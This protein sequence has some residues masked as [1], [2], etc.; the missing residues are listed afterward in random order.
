M[1]RTCI[2]VSGSWMIDQGSL[3]PGYKRA[4]ANDDYIR[5]LAEAG[6]VPLILPF[7]REK[8]RA[9]VLER[10]V[11]LVDGLILSGGHDLY[12]PFYG[13][14]PKQKLSEVWPERDIFDRQLFELMLEAKKPVLGICRGFQL[15]NALNGGELLQDLSYS[16]KPLLKHWQNQSPEMPIHKVFFEPGNVFHE[17]FGP[18]LMVNSHHHQV[19]IAEGS[20]LEVCGRASDGVIEAIADPERKI[21]A[22]QWHPEMMTVNSEPMRQLF[23]HFVESCGE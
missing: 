14:E 12:P 5:S 10:W 22:V 3:F 6:A 2:G 15:I 1:K 7:V 19:V 4:Y 16:E 20:G 11:E 8:D 21:L 13:Q 18:E 17:L 9:G 23:K